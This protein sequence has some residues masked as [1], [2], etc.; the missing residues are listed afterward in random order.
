VK[1]TVIEKSL[2]VS[3]VLLSTD[4]DQDRS[5]KSIAIIF[6]ALEEE[7]YFV[8]QNPLM[9]SLNTFVPYIWRGAVHP[10][11]CEIL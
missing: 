4:A 1:E 6:L 10:R 7:I 11:C 2:E 3:S 9:N 5:I 8:G